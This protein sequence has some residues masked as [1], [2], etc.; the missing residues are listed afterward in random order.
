MIKIQASGDYVQ[1]IYVDVIGESVQEELKSDS[2]AVE[3]SY[4]SN[5]KIYLKFGKMTFDDADP[6]G[7]KIGGSAVI[8]AAD[9]VSKFNALFSFSGGGPAGGGVTSVTYAQLVALIGGSGLTAGQQ[10]LVSDFATVHYIVDANWVQYLDTI[11]TGETE[12]LIVTAAASDKLDKNA[13]S[14]LHPQD[15]IYVDF[16]EANWLNDLSFADLTDP[17]NP[18]IVTGWKGTITFRHDILFD[19]YTG[20][21]FRNCKFRRWKPLVDDYSGLTTY[22][23]GDFV[24]YSGSI[25]QSLQ[26][27]NTN[28]QPDTS[29]DYW[30]ALLNLSKTQYWLPGVDAIPLGPPTDSNSF[31]DFKTFQ[32]NGDTGTYENCCRSNHIKGLKDNFSLESTTGSILSNNVFFLQNANPSHANIYSNEFGIESG[33]NT[34]AGAIQENYIGPDFSYNAVSDFSQNFVGSSM[35]WNFLNAGFSNNVIGTS[36]TRNRIGANFKNNIVGNSF[37]GN[38]VGASCQKNTIANNF[39]AI[40][41]SFPGGCI[42]K[43][44]FTMNTIRDNINSSI[45]FTAATHVYGAY[46]TEIFKRQDGTAKLTYFDNSD[47]LTV[48]NANA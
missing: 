39:G 7:F 12:P 29:Q 40:A 34:F 33:M 32:E 30:V 16:I 46:N 35:V 44:G 41:F 38:V 25:Y 42:I 28:N 20:Y 19:N 14:T 37:N 6:T 10:Y 18:V 17:D 2:D 27:T 26:S 1:L 45:D 11:I 4:S 23:A 24:T 36:I 31:G 21:D 5:G 47:V 9:F 43:N 13:I 8:S 3:V 48:V 22:S 15:I